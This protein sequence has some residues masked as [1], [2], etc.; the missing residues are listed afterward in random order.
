M[1]RHPNCGI[2]TT[3][4]K[5]RSPDC[6]RLVRSGVQ[7]FQ[8]Y[9][10]KFLPSLG[11]AVSFIDGIYKSE[12]PKPFLLLRTWGTKT[13]NNVQCVGGWV[14]QGFPS[15]WGP[16][17]SSRVENR[18]QRVWKLQSCWEEPFLCTDV[19]GASTLK[20]LSGRETTRYWVRVGSGGSG[21]TGLVVA[22]TSR[23]QWKRR[24]S[25]EEEHGSGL[26][27]QSSRGNGLSKS[28][29]A[30]CRW[31]VVTGSW[32]WELLACKVRPE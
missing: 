13:E 14:G 28:Q 6:T 23:G 29:C 9:L 16:R 18:M 10:C 1:H 15:D 22:C 26:A 4:T 25:S 20:K 3:T 2:K 8:K 17:S 11:R 32:L 19:T 31:P 24:I 30:V 27:Q 12:A 5:S 7:L 21:K